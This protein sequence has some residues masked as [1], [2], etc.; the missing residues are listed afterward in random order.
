MAPVYD[1]EKEKLEENNNGQHDD[2]GLDQAQR[3]TEIGDLEDQ[4]AS[5]SVEKPEGDNSLDNDGLKSAEESGNEDPKTSDAENDEQ[6]GLYNDAEDDDRGGGRQK[7]KAR[8]SGRKKGIIGGGIGLLIGGTIGIGSILQGPLALI[9]LSK[10]LAQTHFGFSQDV[11]DSRIFKFARYIYAPDKPERLR[12]TILGNAYTNHLETRIK[13]AGYEI[14]LTDDHLRTLG[15]VYI[16]T[17]QGRYKNLDM[18]EIPDYVKKRYGVDVEMVYNHDTH[19]AKYVIPGNDLKSFKQSRLIKDT[20]V[21]A[22]YSKIGAAIRARFIKTRV[23]WTLRPIKLLDMWLLR[24]ADNAY[25]KWKGDKQAELDGDTK[26][27][28]IRVDTKDDGTDSEKSKTVDETNKH[29]KDIAGPDAPKNPEALRSR[30]TKNPAFRRGASATVV[31]GMG[32]LVKGIADNVDKAKFINIAV[33]MMRLGGDYLSLGQQIMSGQIDMEQ[34]GFFARDLFKTTNP[35]AIAR[36]YQ[37]ATGNELTGPDVPEMAKITKEK[38]TIADLLDIPGL[39]TACNAIS[40]AVGQVITTGIDILTGP[41]SAGAGFAISSTL[42]PRIVDW[43][44]NVFSSGKID[45]N[46][47]NG[48]DLVNVI[49]HGSKLLANESDK[50]AGGRE[51]RPEETKQVNAY[52]KDQQLIENSSKSFFARYF[53]LSDPYSLSGFAVSHV[54]TQ[55]SS[56]LASLFGYPSNAFSGVAKLFT[57]KVLAQ[58]SEEVYEYPFPTYGF[59]IDELSDSRFDNPFEN[60]KYIQDWLDNN[61]TADALIT[62]AKDCYA[63]NLSKTDGSLTSVDGEIKPYRDIP[64]SCASSDEMTLRLRFYILDTLTMESYACYE[65]EQSSCTKFGLGSDTSGSQSTNPPPQSGLETPPNMGGEIANGYYKMPE[66]T[67]GEYEFYAGTPN[68]ERCGSSTLINTIYTVAKRWYAKYPNSKI[69]VGDLNA[70]AGHVSHMTGVDVDIY[71]ADKSAANTG[72]DAEKSK[73]LGRMFA[74]TNVIKLI[75]YNGTA[76]QNDFNSY[77]QGKG[78]SSKMQ[79]SSGHENHF[80]VRILD[81]FI[82]KSSGGCSES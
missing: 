77:A 81:D 40:S 22:G 14:N 79:Y 24:K 35:L 5:P 16:D 78:L 51:L 8:L 1:K 28:E 61:D 72:G 50:S 62:K 49:F 10:V 6:G 53:D 33:P 13:K 44:V 20:L 25:M 52:N 41:V 64:A 26:P 63:V 67:Q 27:T 74:D 75:F 57:G 38:N 73:E 70:S 4:F 11:G 19:I 56:M 31:L 68:N 15:D 45:L 18:T 71:T 82:L 65:G 34:L 12:M 7:K 66:P 47:L 55:P 17:S 59:S 39:N 80:H 21:D 23:G 54:P 32:C 30:I 3:E 29:L 43:L 76:V 9:H 69:Q 37:A 60:G 46:L 2:L 42:V 58:S 48:A 36:A